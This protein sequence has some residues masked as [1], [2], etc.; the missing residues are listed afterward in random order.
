MDVAS[1]HPLDQP[2]DPPLVGLEEP[3]ERVLIPFLRPSQGVKLGDVLWAVFRKAVL[4][5]MIWTSRY[6]GWWRRKTAS[7]GLGSL[8]IRFFVD[9]QGVQQAFR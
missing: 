1:Q 8:R 2:V 6:P 7:F 5:I 4:R 9:C 3:P